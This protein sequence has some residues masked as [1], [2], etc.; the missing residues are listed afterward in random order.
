MDNKLGPTKAP[1]RR[2]TAIAIAPPGYPL[3][4]R[5]MPRPAAVPPV[6]RLPAP[7]HSVATPLPRPHHDPAVSALADDLH[8]LYLPRLT[9]PTDMTDDAA[10]S[11]LRESVATGDRERVHEALA[12]VANPDR[13][14]ERELRLAHAL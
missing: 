8:R 6:T 4:Q 12:A 9:H 10:L 5:G 3:Q 7:A 1:A 2:P 13:P 14:F 11:L